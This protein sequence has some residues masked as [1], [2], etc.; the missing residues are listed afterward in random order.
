VR[1]LRGLNLIGADVVEVGPP[2]DP[3]GT[4][5]LVGATM[6]LEL[7]CVVAD[8]LAARRS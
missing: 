7:L 4:T 6:I 1:A 5:A 2:I 8:A 3:R